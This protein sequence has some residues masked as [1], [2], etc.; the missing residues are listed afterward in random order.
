M[1]EAGD[2]K[3][4]EIEDLLCFCA[5]FLV[6]V[7]LSQKTYGKPHKIVI[8]VLDIFYKKEYNIDIEKDFPQPTECGAPQGNREH[9][10]AVLSADQPTVWALLLRQSKCALIFI[11]GGL[12]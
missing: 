3:P 5:D 9:T 1:A 6:F 7:W 10:V 12:S 11:F 8:Y 4:C 2:S